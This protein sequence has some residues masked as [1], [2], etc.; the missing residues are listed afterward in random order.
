MTRTRA[1][2]W[3]SPLAPLDAPANAISD[4]LNQLVPWLWW[5]LR[6]PA[7]EAPLGAG[8]HAL[9]AVHGAVIYAAA[10]RRFVRPRVALP[11][12]VLSWLWFSGAWDRRARAR[13]SR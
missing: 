4:G 7:R 2:R 13:G 8:A 10:G 11:L 5:P 3:S 9:Y 12:G 6:V 1:D